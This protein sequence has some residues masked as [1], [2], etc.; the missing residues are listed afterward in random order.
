VIEGYLA[1]IPSD[2]Y[3]GVFYITSDGQVESTSKF[4][5]KSDEGK[6]NERQPNG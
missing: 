5:F 2:P 1:S 3:G 6:S 4:V